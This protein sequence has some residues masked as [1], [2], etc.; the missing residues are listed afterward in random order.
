[1]LYKLFD[2]RTIEIVFSGF[3]ETKKAEMVINNEG[4]EIKNI[5]Q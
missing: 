5:F 4:V 2:T 1:M 3:L